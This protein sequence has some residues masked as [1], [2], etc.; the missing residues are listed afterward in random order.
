MNKQYQTK[1]YS[2]HLVI[3]NTLLLFGALILIASRSLFSRFI[4]D[5]YCHAYIAHTK[6]FMGAQVY[7]YTAW[8]GKYSYNF[9]VTL[10]QLLGLKI[11]P[12]I[13]IFVLIVWVISL[14]WTLYE[15][16]Q[17]FEIKANTF[18]IF[19]IT[20]V[21]IFTHL[22]SIPTIGQSFYWQSTAPYTLPIILLII[23]IGIIIRCTRS[24]SH[25]FIMPLIVFVLS[26]TAGGFSETFVVMQTTLLT[27]SIFLILKKYTFHRK[28]TLLL[29]LFA[30]LLG[31]CL[32]FFITAI[33]PGNK[34][35]QALYPPPNNLIL[36]AL[37]TIIYSFYY[38]LASLGAF[39]GGLFIVPI[40]KFLSIDN[41]PSH[42]K[43][44]QPNIPLVSLAFYIV[45]L[46]CIAPNFFSIS[47]PPFNRNLAI[48]NFVIVIYSAFMGYLSGYLIPKKY[49]QILKFTTLVLLLVILLYS[50]FLMSSIPNYQTHAMK[51]DQQH[52]YILSQKN[53]GIKNITVVA[54]GYTEGLED[55]Q[56]DP[57][58]WVNHCMAQ[59]YGIDTIKA[60]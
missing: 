15:I 34:I 36:P 52:N 20:L 8:T 58:H 4:A 29:F 35:R 54:L 9:F 27:I 31:S 12:L 3:V 5:E 23:Y 32:S 44:I 60:Q 16:V 24:K 46:A 45:I 13:P 21:I 14:F 2:S 33:A 56:K 40:A 18:Y 51:W 59:Y 55:V 53:K 28:K 37:Q 11:F 10:V 1:K 17:F 30:A 26:F 50:Y 49:S 19:Y 7:W 47:S 22:W 42:I 43:R 57:N 6:T 41:I 25:N 48:P 38:L 39:T